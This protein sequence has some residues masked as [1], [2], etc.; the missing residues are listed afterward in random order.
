MAKCAFDRSDSQRLRHAAFARPR[1]DA[2]WAE[3]LIHNTACAIA[4]RAGKSAGSGTNCAVQAFIAGYWPKA[5]WGESGCAVSQW[6]R[7]KLNIDDKVRYNTTNAPAANGDPFASEYNNQMLVAYLA[8]GGTIEEAW[9][10]AFPC[11][12]KWNEQRV[13]KDHSD[14]N[15]YGDIQPWLSAPS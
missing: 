5:F 15:K 1:K 12:G 2:A 14:R 10:S 7:R 6:P 11:A 8:N 3:T 13:D 4:R 9:Y